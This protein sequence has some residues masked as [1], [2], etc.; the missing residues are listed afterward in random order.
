MVARVEIEQRLAR[1]CLPKERFAVALRRVDDAVQPGVRGVELAEPRVHQR[2]V[3]QLGAAGVEILHRIGSGEGFAVGGEYSVQ[4]AALAGLGGADEHAPIRV[5][6]RHAS[7][8]R[9]TLERASSNSG[10]Q[11]ALALARARPSRG[12]RGPAVGSLGPRSALRGLTQR[13]RIVAVDRQQR[14]RGRGEHVAHRPGGLDPAHHPYGEG[15]RGS[16]SQSLR[17]F[18]ACPSG[19]SKVVRSRRKAQP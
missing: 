5:V 2:E 7:A 13:R 17:V 9:I 14:R 11:R 10:L 3:E 16:R 8:S 19:T 12:A 1:R 18:R 15:G 6:A 4:V